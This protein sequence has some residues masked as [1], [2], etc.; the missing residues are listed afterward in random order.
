MRAIAF[1]LLGFGVAACASG[2]YTPSPA[3][4]LADPVVVNL[5]RKAFAETKLPGTMQI[6]RP[7]AAH[8]VSPGD[9]L[10]CMRSSDRSAPLLYAVY[11]NGGMFVTSRMAVVIDRC[12]QETYAGFG[13]PPKPN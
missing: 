9:W 7:R 8:L 5:I 2:P 12:E 4:D 13:D 6:T 3:P 10:I 1:L 11:F